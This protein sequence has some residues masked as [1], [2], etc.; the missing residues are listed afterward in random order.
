[1]TTRVI[2]LDLSMQASGVA[3]ASGQ[4]FTIKPRGKGDARLVEFEDALC[5]YLGRKSDQP[6]VAVIEEVASQKG[7]GSSGVLFMIHG[8]ARKVLAAAGIPFVYI[9][10][11]TLKKY[12]TGSGAADKKLMIHAA[13]ERGAEPADDNQADAAWLRWAGLHF[14]DGRSVLSQEMSRDLIFPPSTKIKWPDLDAV[15]RRK[16]RP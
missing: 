14:Y 10:N 2:G 12:A 6:H 11:G 9:H 13:R 8:V 16:A 5:Y 1:M 15:N 7:F 4:L 3:A